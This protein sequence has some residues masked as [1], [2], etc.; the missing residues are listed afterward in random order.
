MLPNESRGET[1]ARPNRSVAGLERNE[2]QIACREHGPI[3]LI[4]HSGFRPL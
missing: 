3:M 2:N 4:S 1:I